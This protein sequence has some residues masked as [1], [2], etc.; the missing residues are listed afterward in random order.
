MLPVPT[1]ARPT[2]APASS[3]WFCRLPSPALN[4]AHAQEAPACSLFS[5][6][7]HRREPRES[8]G[9]VLPP[10]SQAPGR[11]WGAEG[12]VSRG[13][14]PRRPRVWEEGHTLYAN[15]GLFCM[16][17]E[18]TELGSLCGPR[19]RIAWL[20][21]VPLREAWVKDWRQGSIFAQN[22]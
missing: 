3:P 18:W 22:S 14:G 7:S 21:G 11:T 1:R 4:A 17:Y 5:H 13:R 16:K 2:P 15:R 20:V 6:H 8:L 12:C 10:A 9:A 19:R